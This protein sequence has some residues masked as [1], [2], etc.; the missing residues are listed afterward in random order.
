ML[1]KPFQS[2]NRN[3]L[4]NKIGKKN[5]NYDWLIKIIRLTCDNG[6]VPNNEIINFLFS[7]GKKSLEY[8][9]RLSS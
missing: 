8:S 3:H 1:P 5:E 4:R 2:R 7:Q 6:K 9:R